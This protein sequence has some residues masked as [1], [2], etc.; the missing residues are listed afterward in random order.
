MTKTKNMQS[1]SKSVAS[2]Q[3]FIIYN[4]L[5]LEPHH[6]KTDNCICENKEHSLTA[7]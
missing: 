1:K 6:E 4:Y 7:Q 3:L 2:Q 5:S